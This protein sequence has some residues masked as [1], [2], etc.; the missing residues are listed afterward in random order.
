MHDREQVPSSSDRAG[1]TIRSAGHD[2]AAVAFAAA[3]ARSGR[4][5]PPDTVPHLQRAAGNSAVASLFGDDLDGSLV[6]SVVGSDGSGQPLDAS[7]QEVMESHLGA[8]LSDVRVHTDAR[9]SESA[10]AINAQAYTAGNHIVFQRAAYQPGT[11]SGLHMLAH[12]LTHVV[13]QRNGPVD[14][15]PVAGG[16]NVSDP[17]DRFEQA[18]ERNADSI[19]RSIGGSGGMA[20]LQRAPEPDD[21]DLP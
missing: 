17:S 18:A 8:D 3:A 6:H 13:Q 4:R 12:E 14:G 15:T 5:V 16:V 21:D 9:A 10:A 19:L 1:R 2:S 7:V 11:D 20:A